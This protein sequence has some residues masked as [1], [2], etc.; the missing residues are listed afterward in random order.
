MSH[1]QFTHVVARL[2]RK[3]EHVPDPPDIQEARRI[4]DGIKATW[5]ASRVQEEAYLDAEGTFRCDLFT[6]AKPEIKTFQGTWEGRV[7]MIVRNALGTDTTW[8]VVA[9]GWNILCD[10]KPDAV[11]LYAVHRVASALFH[12]FRHLPENPDAGEAREIA[13]GIKSTYTPYDLEEEAYKT[14]KGQIGCKIVVLGDGGR[15]IRRMT[16][17]LGRRV[18]NLLREESWPCSELH[19]TYDARLGCFHCETCDMIGRTI[20]L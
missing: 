2:R 12:K 14:A 17:E 10:Q 4:A 7:G 9:A 18:Q 20:G 15:S 5:D 11:V 13:E 6:L 3:F 16:P 1:E 8:H 19:V